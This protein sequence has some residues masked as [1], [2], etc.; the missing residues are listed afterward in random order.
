MWTFCLEPYEVPE[1][2]PTFI[3]HKLKRRPLSPTKKGKTKEGHETTYG[4]GEGGSGEA[5]MGGGY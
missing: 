1:V 4:G 5:K 2:D 3:M